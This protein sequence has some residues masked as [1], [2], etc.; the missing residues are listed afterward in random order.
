MPYD[1]DIDETKNLLLSLNVI[2]DIASIADGVVGRSGDGRYNEILKH[3][4]SS[5]DGSLA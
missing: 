2:S 3:S 4:I 5:L 1:L